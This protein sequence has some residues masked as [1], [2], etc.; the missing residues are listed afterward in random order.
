MIILNSMHSINCSKTFVLYSHIHIVMSWTIQLVT[1]S[2][3]WCIFSSQCVTDITSSSINLSLCRPSWGIGCQHDYAR[4]SSPEPI[5]PTASTATNFFDICFQIVAPGVSRSSS[6]PFPF[7]NTGQGL[8]CNAVDWFR[9]IMTNPSSPPLSNLLFD[10]HLTC[11]LPSPFITDD[12]R[13]PPRILLRQ[14]STKVCNLFA[15]SDHCGHPCLC[16]VQKNSLD[17]CIEDSDLVSQWKDVGFPNILQL[18]KGRPCLA[19]PSFNVCFG[20]ALCVNDA[21]QI[22]ETVD[23]FYRFHAQCNLEYTGWV[24]FEDLA[25]S[26]MDIQP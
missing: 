7:W 23:L 11:A 4:H 8:W 1:K 18:K 5:S 12:F 17:I 19:S 13:P 3:S 20:S 24:H 15:V 16:S 25:L 2:E 6:F 10:Q 21:A 9:E 22:C 14:L 26:S